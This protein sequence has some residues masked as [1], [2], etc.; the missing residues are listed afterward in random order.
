MAHNISGIITSFKYEGHLPNVALVG[1][2]HLIPIDGSHGDTSSGIPIPPYEELTSEI[3]ETI[4]DLSIHGK[5]AYIETAYFGG[6]GV[7]RSETWENQEKTDGPFI[8]YDGIENKM[9]YDGVTI[10]DGSINQALKN[11]GFH[12]QEGKDEFDTIGLGRYRSN[13]KILEAYNNKR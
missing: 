13:S 9:E 2:Y 7:Q 6:L 10:V 11:I 4:K 8:S 5:C 3:R 12:R 1:D